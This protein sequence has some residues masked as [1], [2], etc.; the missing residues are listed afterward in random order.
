MA[1]EMIVSCSSRE[2]KVA[3]LEDNQLEEVYFERE[4]EYSIAGSIYKGRVT[5]VLP[6]MQSAFVDI[7]LERDAFLY[8]SDFFEDTEE[9]DKIVTVIEEKV[10]KME[11]VRAGETGGG[12]MPLPSGGLLPTAPAEML[13]PAALP[14]RTREEKAPPPGEPPHHL[15]RHPRRRRSRGRGFPESKYARRSPYEGAQEGPRDPGAGTVATPIILPGESLA[16]Y[17]NWG[18]SPG[19]APV[20]ERKETVETTAGA[21]AEPLGSVAAQPVESPAAEVASPPENPDGMV[22]AVE[23][24]TA[25]SAAE[26]APL[27]PANQGI[28]P[29]AGF[30]EVQ[31]PAAE[32][33]LDEKARP[34]EVQV[35]GSDDGEQIRAAVESRDGSWQEEGLTGSEGVAAPSAIEGSG[36]VFTPEAEQAMAPVKAE[37]AEAG[38]PERE[39]KPPEESGMP[40]EAAVREKGRNPRYQR[41]G[42]WSARREP[43]DARA[44][45]RPRT[46]E[47][48]AP[49]PLIADLLKEGQEIIVQVA[50]E[51]LGKKG[52]R[53]TSHI[54][55]PGRYL[56]YM[57]TVAHIGISHKIASEQE[58]L[59]LKRILR[60]LASGVTGGFIVRTAGEG[61]SLEDFRQDVLF[62]TKLWADFRSQAEKL[63]AP[64][65]LHRDLDLIQRTLRDQLSEDFTA[66]WVD[67]EPE[68]ESLVN[69]VSRFQPSLVGR[70]KLYT[71]ATPLFEAMGIQEELNKALKSKVWLKSG[72]YIVLNQTEALV[73]IDVN[74][75]KFVGKSNRL[76][77]TIVK[78]NVDA[79]QEIVRQ[80]RLRDLGGIIVIDFIDMDERKNRQKVM[81]ALEEALKADRAPSKILP[82]NEFGLVSI[83]RKRV[84]QSL[85]RTLCDPCLYCNGSGFVKSVATVCCEILSE[86]RKMASQLEG[87]QVTLRVNPEVGKS[88]KA[89]DNT[90]LAEI[91]ELTGKSVLVR[92]DPMLHVENFDFE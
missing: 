38:S 17:K 19:S 66:V 10:S 72:G 80:I 55:L 53:I 92:N 74:T 84:R 16:K 59:R 29:Q 28:V 46:R 41:K 76:E 39:E 3:I 58:R 14:A 24:S 43:R 6:G 15:S 73:A 1:K 18:G 49:K 45:Q 69:W 37:G 50:K 86:A 79:I 13:P 54:A 36:E 32:N 8:V 23:E 22:L 91:E 31:G 7:G 9:Y 47:Q 56:V 61:R 26:P 33:L 5:R 20:E 51:A 87:K 88:L 65:L 77:D 40:Q 68:Y 52:A 60:E 85:E 35:I 62:L 90:I 67:N 34:A 42:R 78:T 12:A 48:E 70:V 82:F 57:P 71:K 89:R 81:T 75:G 11:E 44:D 30:W 27:S 64:A 2:R 4:K 63:K 25:V 83:T 21:E